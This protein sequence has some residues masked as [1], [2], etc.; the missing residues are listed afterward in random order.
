MSL[1]TVEQGPASLEVSVEE[2]D[3]RMASNVPLLVVQDDGVT[4][5]S[6][7]NVRK[8]WT[9]R[10]LKGAMYFSMSFLSIMSTMIV[11]YRWVCF[12]VRTAQKR[13]ANAAV[14]M[15]SLL[16]YL[17]PSA[18]EEIREEKAKEVV[19]VFLKT[20]DNF[21]YST[22]WVTFVTD[23]A[24]VDWIVVLIGVVT[25]L[26]GSWYGLKHCGIFGRQTV[27][28]L[29][30]I[31]FE[32]VREGSS[33]R[34]ATIPSYQVS[35]REAGVFTDTHLGFGVR[36]GDYL[37]TPAHVVEKEGVIQQSILLVGAKSKVFVTVSAIRS[38]GIDDLVYIYV[39]AK[40]WSMLGV[41]KAKV[42][43]RFVGTHVNCTGYSGQSTGRLRKAPI[44]W[45]LTYTGSTLP[46]MSGSAYEE[47]GLVMGL[48]QGAS[49]SFNLGISSELMVAEM[50][51]ICVPES[52]ADVNPD[53]KRPKFFGG[54]NQ[55][56]WDG[57]KALEHLDS[58]YKDSWIGADEIDYNQTLN[59]DEESAGSK[60][61]TVRVPAQGIR[62]KRE[63]VENTE[64]AMV[65]S[66]LL[67]FITEMREQNVLERLQRLETRFDSVPVRKTPQPV[68]EKQS[69]RCKSCEVVCRT[70][71]RLLNHELSSHPTI[72]ESAV[73]CDTGKTGK[74]VK[75]GSFLGKRPNSPRIKDKESLM[76]SKLSARKNLSQPQEV[77]LSGLLNSQKNIE[78][79]LSQ[80]LASLAGPS[81]DTKRN[82]V[83]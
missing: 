61:V 53:E 5:G 34:N 62:L 66:D 20:L 40:T 45:L 15:Y 27:Q 83:V 68:P 42:S 67:D 72:G 23:M 32:S 82:C 80:L 76:N 10:L 64:I 74:V 38:R 50:K 69:F 65:P 52:S 22:P 58:R 6:T 54:D 7:N 14:D 44:R 81:S 36:Y 25:V 55:S 13:I 19:S 73:P 77:N 71:Q 3:S 37:V 47:S 59:F 48:H 75:T 26:L 2:D 39:D 49:G 33:F 79:C 16:D 9:T 46:G 57:I 43:P 17:S 12:G 31:R 56:V 18:T 41:S 63:G 30:G 4:L 78:R 8:S 29:R 51:K 28:K 70:H 60:P 1:N 35:I 21:V 11:S 24:A